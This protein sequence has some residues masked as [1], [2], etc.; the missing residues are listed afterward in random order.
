[1]RGALVVGLH[2]RPLAGVDLLGGRA[3]AWRRDAAQEVGDG[4]VVTEPGAHHL[5]H[6]AE[7]AGAGDRAGVRDEVAGDDAQQRR[8]ARAV[9]ADQGDLRPLADPEGHVVEQH[10]P[11]RQL[12]AHPGNVHV[13]HDRR[14]SVIAGTHGIP[15]S[16]QHVAD[17][18]RR[19]RHSTP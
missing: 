17:S 9:R 4:R 2:Q 18:R 11:V 7:P 13:S 16:C 12:V 10:P 14:F 6:D 19:S 15:I 3:D 1:V 5:A 8:L